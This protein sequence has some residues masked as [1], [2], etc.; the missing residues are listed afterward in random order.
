MFA[1]TLGEIA[2]VVQGRLV[3]GSGEV[4]VRGVTT[5]SRE[6]KA[7]HLF[8]CLRGERF[9]GHDFVEA[10]RAAGVA[11]ALVERALPSSLPQVVVGDTLKAL[12]ALARWWRRRQGALVIGVTGS[13]G[14]TTTKGMLAAVLGQHRPTLSNP[15]T[16]NNEIG[17]PRTLL[18]LGG[19]AYCVL[20]MGARGRGQIAYLAQVAA[21]QIGV[22]TNIGE[23]HLGLIG[24]REQVAAAKGELLAALPPE[25]TAVLNAEDF[26]F[27]VLAELAPCRVVSFGLERGDFRAEEVEVGIEGTSF[28]L[29]GPAGRAQVRVRLAGRHNAVNAA[30]A[31]A[32]AWAAGAKLE[33][34]VAGL[35]A[36]EGEGMRSQ[37]VRRP[38]GAVIINDAYN[39][40]P[41]SVQAALELLAAMPGRKVMVFGD[42]LELGEYAQE[43]HERVGR[44]AAQAGVAV[45]VAVG[46]LAKAAGAV[47]Q[48]SGVQV[49]Y[50]DSP[51]EALEL[52][53]E[54]VQPG[55]V[56][57]VKASRLVGLE[58]V[59]EGLGGGGQD[60]H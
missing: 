58:R 35:E 13:A 6:A 57:L 18:R 38:D 20:E 46:P 24:S 26:F 11:A 17:V 44:A 34:I 42:M 4:V 22:I 60:V 43:A 16:E 56:V 45:M 52:A 27:G 47:A 41:T 29:A 48:H 2:A 54:I 5:D 59:A 21:P 3:S 36:Y 12:G 7:G 33:H 32:A 28:I 53:E 31:A 39:A 50:A 55:D 15:G 49:L 19:E 9:D 14:K 51:E 8:V 25:G 30:A 1:A 40:S 37:I 10:A 23:A